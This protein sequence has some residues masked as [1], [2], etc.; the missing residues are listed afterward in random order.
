MSGPGPAPLV[1]NGWSLFSHSLFLDQ[2]AEL[3]ATVTELRRRDPAGYHGKN[4]TKRL[5][6]ILKLTTET[7]PAD[8]TLPAYRQGD[9]LGTAHRHWFRAKFFQQYRLFFRYDS[10]SRIIVYAW[11]N[12]DATRRAY[13]SR[14][15]VYRVFK[16]MLDS[17]QPPGDWDA[18][19]AEAR[20][21][22]LPARRDKSG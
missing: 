17:G 4:P 22:D 13:D 12:D 14:T 3:E 5:A 16:G 20:R 10:A 6:A 18:L 1:V 7:I 2:I 21:E 19:L 9:T 15:D 8:P 11:V